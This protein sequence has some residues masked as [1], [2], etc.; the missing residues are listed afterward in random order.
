[1]KKGRQKLILPVVFGKEGRWHIAF[2]P[3]LD[4]ATQG[5]S[6]KEAR[7]NIEDLIREYLSDPDVPKPDLAHLR[8]PMLSYVEIVAPRA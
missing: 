7:E 1:M 2:C 4:V 6:E 3:V 8:F 5:L